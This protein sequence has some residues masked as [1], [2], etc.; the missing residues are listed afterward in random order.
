[1]LKSRVTS[2]IENHISNAQLFQLAQPLK[3]RG[4]HDIPTDFIK[5]DIAVDGV[6]DFLMVLELVA[7][8]V[9]DGVM[10]ELEVHFWMGNNKFDK[11]RGLGE[12]NKF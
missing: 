7:V 8:D 9:N 12:I 6:I 2:S 3:N 1:M 4:V 10:G 11:K 5:V